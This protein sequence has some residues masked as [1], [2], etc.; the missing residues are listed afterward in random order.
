MPL[1]FG[2]YHDPNPINA[3][4]NRNWFT[5]GTAYQFGNFNL[6]ISGAFTTCDYKYHDL[7]PIAVEKRV[8]F[9]TVRESYLIGMATLRYNF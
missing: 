8:E 3:E 2:F 9:D 6:E 7:F 4:M 1:R 5:A